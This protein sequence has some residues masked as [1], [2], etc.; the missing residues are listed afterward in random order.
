MA[1]FVSC[2]EDKISTSKKPSAEI[3][4]Q[5]FT[6]PQTTEIDLPTA[7][8][9]VQASTALHLLAKD[10]V[11]QLESNASAEERV[12]ILGGFEKA[13]D[14]LLRKIGLYGIE[15]F[16]WISTE[17]IKNPQNIKVFEAA[18]MQVSTER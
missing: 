18:G 1:S 15:H 8:K 14:Q 2:K 12:L 17:A 6:P 9:F 13:R 5:K 3:S 10:W 4:H 11:T 16:N 7:Q